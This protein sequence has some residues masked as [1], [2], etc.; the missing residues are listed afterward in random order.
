MR[1]FI[2]SASVAATAIVAAVMLAFYTVTTAAA[3]TALMI[4]GIGVPS[5]PDLFMR[6]ISGGAYQNYDRVSVPWPAEARGYTGE[7]DLLLGESID[8]GVENLY[9]EI[10]ARDAGDPEGHPITVVGMSAGALVVTEVLRILADDP[11]APSAD[12][13][14]F[15]VMA[16]SSRQE[17][18]N[19]NSEAKLG[20]TYQ[21]PP[22]TIYETVQV[23]A[24]YDGFADF[25]DKFPLFH[26]VSVIN[27]YLGAVT[28]HNATF[29]AD[30]SEV[31]AEDITVEV[32][33]L[34]GVTTKYFLR[35]DELPIVTVL[36]FLK[37]IEPQLKEIV[38]R[39]YTRNDEQAAAA[40]RT[41]ASKVAA[42]LSAPAYE[43]DA[44]EESE[45]VV[46]EESVDSDGPAETGSAET[47]SDDLSDVAD[48]LA[49]VAD[50]DVSD[51][52]DDAGETEVAEDAEEDFAEAEAELEA[53]V[54]ASAEDS[55][56]AEDETTGSSA[57]ESTGASTEDDE[58]ADDTDSESA[59]DDDTSAGEDSA[60]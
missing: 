32:N 29:F 14:N 59:S 33:E 57:A 38:D 37:S 17:F 6:Q 12:R 50:E 45:V 15:V 10:L 31:D 58:S 5:M 13:L 25:P 51:G 49:D 42:P 24:E 7:N 47:N 35:A 16:D 26:I 28:R 4:G 36:P 43:S 18:V 3:Q 60:A 1:G 44:A 48:E 55:D 2:R 11:D 56:S 8:I 54:E 23:T 21:P 52:A 27:A 19:T 46:T 30:L 22:D 39:G 20:Y 34:G 9:N 41:T 40:A 53:A